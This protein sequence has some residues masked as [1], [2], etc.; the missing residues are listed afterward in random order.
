MAKRPRRSR[1]QCGVHWAT[2]HRCDTGAAYGL[3]QRPLCSTNACQFWC[4]LGTR[5][6]AVSPHA[7]RQGAAHG[8]GLVIQ[9]D[10]VAAAGG[11]SLLVSDPTGQTRTPCRRNLVF[12]SLIYMNILKF[13]KRLHCSHLASTVL[14]TLSKVGINTAALTPSLSNSLRSIGT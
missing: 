1:K 8:A 14:A 11:V 10:W 3:G 5:R 13:L 2:A 9:T 6:A 4:R 12:R 7:L